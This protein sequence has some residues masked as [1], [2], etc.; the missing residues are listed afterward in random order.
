MLW[1]YLPL[2][3]HN[4][5]LILTQVIDLGPSWQVT[6]MNLI[7]NDFQK[8]SV[9]ILLVRKHSC[10]GKNCSIWAIFPLSTMFSCFMLQWRLN[11][12]SVVG[13][14]K[15]WGQIKTYTFYLYEMCYY[16][17]G[18]NCSFWINSA[19]ATKI[20]IVLIHKIV[21]NSRISDV[22]LSFNVL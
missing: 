15:A 8:W 11:L 7:E 18:I 4:H 16:L 3:I 2:V 6:W 14:L 12:F 17:K 13:E 1:I 22:G 5:L 9:C 21:K 10:Q 19:F 20:S